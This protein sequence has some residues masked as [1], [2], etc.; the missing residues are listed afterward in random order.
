MVY[1]VFVALNFVIDEPVA[2]ANILG[3]RD[4]MRSV[5]IYIYIY[6]YIYNIHIYIYNIYIY[7]VG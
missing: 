3:F 7:I 6:I 2:H 5:P 4:G 1:G